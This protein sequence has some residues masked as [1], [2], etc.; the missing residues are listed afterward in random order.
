MQG[1]RVRGQDRI[2]DREDDARRVRE[3]LLAF[4]G[5]YATF[6]R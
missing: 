2:V 1:R 3:L 4:N 5:P 6:A